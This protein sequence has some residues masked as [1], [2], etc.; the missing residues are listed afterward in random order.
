M[1]V[2]VADGEGEAKSDGG[3]LQHP[4]RRRSVEKSNRLQEAAC[5]LK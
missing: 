5:S 4:V 3:G 1:M 2:L